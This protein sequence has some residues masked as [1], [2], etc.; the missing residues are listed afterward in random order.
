MSELPD[1]PP[2][3]SSKE[4]GET[5]WQRSCVLHKELANKFHGL[6]TAAAFGTLWYLLDLEQHLPPAA[7]RSPLA[8]QI[9][10]HAAYLSCV[11]GAIH[12]WLEMF[13][14]IH[15]YNAAAKSILDFREFGE[16]EAVRLADRRT[17]RAMMWGL[18]AYAHV[19]FL[20]AAF[21]A[22]AFYKASNPG[23]E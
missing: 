4:F 7:S 3:V 20:I 1:P 21:V 23:A 14:P 8:I 12:L 16:S 9:S 18:P 22:A 10:W 6:T 11:F 15:A 17:R 5:L 2:E 19:F 13:L